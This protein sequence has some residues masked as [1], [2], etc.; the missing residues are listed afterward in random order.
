MPGA[1]QKPEEFFEVNA[2]NCTKEFLAEQTYIMVHTVYLNKSCKIKPEMGKRWKEL[3]GIYMEDA[4]FDYLLGQAPVMLRDVIMDETRKHKEINSIKFIARTVAAFEF[5]LWL[6]ERYRAGMKLVLPAFESYLREKYGKYLQHQCGLFIKYD[7]MYLTDYKKL[8]QA[9]EPHYD[10]ILE[11]FRLLVANNRMK[12]EFD[13]ENAERTKDYERRKDVTAASAE[14]PKKP[15]I[16]SRAQGGP[17]QP[18]DRGSEREYQIILK[19]KDERIEK[20]EKDIREFK[21]QRDEAREYSA[22]QYDR[23]VRDLFN[24]MNDIRYGKVIDYLYALSQNPG[25]EANLSSYLDNLFMALEDMEIEPIAEDGRLDVREESLL[26][27]FNLDFDKS[28]YHAEKVR[29]K[30]AGWRYRD[31]PMEKPTL[32]LKEV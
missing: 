29:L 30:Y 8:A 22:N 7:L 32:T 17:G 18:A 20:L 3:F 4:A 25:T 2:V 10:Q 27:N 6:I 16:L 14:S 12:I 15:P 5:D 24:V 9:L 21:R 23:G 26:K 11:I 1:R 19:E 31:I 13:N 28:E